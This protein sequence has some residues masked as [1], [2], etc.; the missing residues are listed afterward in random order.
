MGAAFWDGF[1]G[2]VMWWGE[3]GGRR[4]VVEYGMS[5]VVDGLG[6]LET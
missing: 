3:Y 6:G 2:C 1:G 4:R 5:E